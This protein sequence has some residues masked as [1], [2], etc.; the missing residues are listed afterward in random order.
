VGRK[1]PHL[2]STPGC[3]QIVLTGP[4]KC[5]EHARGWDR[6][7]QTPEGQRRGVGYSHSWRKVRDAYIGEHA[8]CERCGRPAAEVHHRDGRHPSERGANDWRNL[9]AVCVGCHRALEREARRLPGGR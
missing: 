9:M 6:W 5:P 4:G 7:R 8:V 2:C 3:H 1:T